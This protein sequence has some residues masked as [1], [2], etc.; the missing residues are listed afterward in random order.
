M[1]EIKKGTKEYEEWLN[2]CRFIRK[3][4]QY[5]SYQD[6][7]NEKLGI[8]LLYIASNDLT[9]ELYKYYVYSRQM[10]YDRKKEIWDYLNEPIG[11]LTN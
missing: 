6:F 7:L 5:Y 10:S 11:K 8:K 1:E 2:S 9:K 3:E 4:M